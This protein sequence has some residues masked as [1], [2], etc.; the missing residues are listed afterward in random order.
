MK[1][2]QY[3]T[4]ITDTREQKPYTFQN[5]KPEPPAVI[6][7]GLK[8]GD[9]SVV[10]LESKITIERKSLSDLFGSAGKGRKRLE[11]EFQRM[12][13]FDYAAIL[14]ESSLSDI[15]VNPPGRS[16]MNPK[17]VFRTLIS[18]SVKY[19]VCVWP[20]WSRDAAERVCYLIL[21][22]YYNNYYNLKG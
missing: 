4:I 5:I 11:S 7:Q 19:N 12:N 14:I 16:K 3:F 8:T 20:C 1:K 15:F 21:N 2:I 6:R 10:G 22:N 18:W 13:K 17:A 9:Y